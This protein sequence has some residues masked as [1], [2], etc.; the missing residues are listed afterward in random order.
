MKMKREIIYSM[1]GYT[2]WCALGL[3]RGIKSYNYYINEHKSTES[4]MYLQSS[5]HGLFGIFLYGNPLFFPYFLYKELYRL[6][7]NIRN[8]EK[9]K[10]TIWYNDLL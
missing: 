9:E 7:I 10:N 2:S 8:L 3:N 1:I 4:Y 5:I 6:E